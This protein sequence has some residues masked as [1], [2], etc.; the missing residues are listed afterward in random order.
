M[1]IIVTLFESDKVVHMEFNSY[2]EYFTD[3]KGFVYN[4]VDG[5]EKIDVEFQGLA[6]N[7][8]RSAEVRIKADALILR[9]GY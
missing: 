6:P 9:E 5:S 4:N 1:T 7:S 2:T 8:R 3:V